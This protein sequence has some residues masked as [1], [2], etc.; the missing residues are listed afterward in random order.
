MASIVELLVPEHVTTIE[1][2]KVAAALSVRLADTV[3]TPGVVQ[4]TIPVLPTVKLADALVVSVP[5]SVMVPLTVKVP[6]I[7]IVGF[8]PNGIVV[9]LLIVKGADPLL[10]VQRLNVKPAMSIVPE[11]PPVNVIVPPLA[12]NVGEFVFVIPRVFVHVPLVAVNA[13][14]LMVNDVHWNDVLPSVNV[15]AAIENAAATM[16]TFLV[17]IPEYVLAIVKVPALQVPTLSMV[18]FLTEVASNVIESVVTG[19]AAPFQAA[20][21]DQLSSMRADH[22]LAAI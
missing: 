4:V 7:V 3:N 6:L 12:L 1:L 19:T 22:V 2:G 5:V 10:M 18:Q 16:A 13:P 8:V 14:P 15:P 21:V 11:D 20:A 17:M 9:P